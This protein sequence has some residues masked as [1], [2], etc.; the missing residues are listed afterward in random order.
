V[1]FERYVIAADRRDVRARE[2]ATI[3]ARRERDDDDDDDDAFDDFDG[4]ARRG[5]DLG[6]VCETLDEDRARGASR[7]GRGEATRHR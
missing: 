3:D 4:C 1:F 5:G 7:A 6:R 2:C